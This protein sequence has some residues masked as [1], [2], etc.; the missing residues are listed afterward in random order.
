MVGATLVGVKSVV[1]QYSDVEIGAKDISHE[2]HFAHSPFLGLWDPLMINP[3]PSH[4]HCHHVLS[5]PTKISHTSN[6]YRWIEILKKIPSKTINVGT[7]DERVRMTY[8]GYFVS[9]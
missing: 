1:C 7:M 8:W 9:H 5:A 2:R 4:T 3:P 6:C